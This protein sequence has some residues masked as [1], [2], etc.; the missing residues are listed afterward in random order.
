MLLYFKTSNNLSFNEEVT[1]STIAGNYK[2]TNELT[3]ERE[4]ELPQNVIPIEKYKVNAL[5]TSVIYGANASGKSNLL[6]AILHAAL[7]IQDNFT[8]SN[9][10][11]YLSSN[12]EGFYN[13]NNAANLS[14]PV[15]FSFGILINEVQFEYHF[16]YNNERVVAESLY[17]YRTQKPI[18]HFDRIFNEK[19]K[20]Y[21]WRFSKYFTGEK[22]TVKNITNQYTLYLTV[23]SVSK[24]SICEQVFKWFDSTV[25]GS[26]DIDHPGSITDTV[27]LKGM[28]ESKFIKELVLEQ[29]KIAD[30]SIIDFE[31]EV[32]KENELR[33]TTIHK[34]IGIDGNDSTA[35]FD[36]FREES[37]G[38]RRF[39]GWLGFLIS[40][41][42]G[43]KVVLIDEFGTSMHS[44]LS[45]H[46]LQN[47]NGFA[48][49]KAQLIFTTHDTNLMT[50]ELFR[51]DQI[52]IAEK[53]SFG[54]SKLFPLSEFKLLKG[55]DLKTTYMQGLYGGIPHFKTK[56]DE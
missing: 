27:I 31:I 17:E 18:E 6:V 55:K 3:G 41:M 13:K 37:I 49:S 16:S 40:M 33:V 11:S 45:K 36:Y 1:F 14:R 43:G 10:P 25:D 46:L 4:D 52:W 39:I 7:F 56:V 48:K 21:E 47:I 44:L 29:L 38:T 35:R 32:E 30:F 19:K 24:L 53:D 5:R 26:F 22:E 51:P 42:A 28:S 2:V 8:K 12:F 54:N 20:I 15:T 34:S 23:G 50:R 9:E